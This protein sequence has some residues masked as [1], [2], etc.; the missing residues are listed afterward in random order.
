MKQWQPDPAVL[1][2]MKEHM[3]TVSEGEQIAIGTRTLTWEELYKEVEVG[4]TD[5]ARG[6][7]IA[8]LEGYRE[9]FPNDAK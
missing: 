8:Y 4:S 3:R 6:Y 2:D 5:F 1:A 9:R 7:Y